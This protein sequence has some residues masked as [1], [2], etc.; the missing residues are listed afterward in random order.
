M[1]GETAHACKGLA[2]HTADKQFLSRVNSHVVLQRPVL[3]KGPVAQRTA[4]RLL[5]RVNST[6]GRQTR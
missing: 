3:T 4:V 5:A 6:V 1:P 2:T